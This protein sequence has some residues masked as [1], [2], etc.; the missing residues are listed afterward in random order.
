MRQDSIKRTLI[1]LVISLCVVGLTAGSG[2]ASLAEKQT[3]SEKLDQSS[4]AVAQES[5]TAISLE[6][7]EGAPGETVDVTLSATANDVSSYQ[8][9]ITFD[10]SIV[11]A[12]TAQSGDLGSPIV[13]INN[14]S[15]WV[16]LTATQV[17]GVDDPTLATITFELVGDA[18]QSS[19]LGLFEAETGLSD[20]QGN[21]ISVDEYNQGTVSIIDADP[22]YDGEISVDRTS[23]DAGEFVAVDVSAKA[24]DVVGFDTTIDFDPSVASV[25]TVNAGEF[26]EINSTIDNTT[27]NV[28]LSGDGAATDDP[29]LATVEFQLTGET[30]TQTDLL[31]D[32]ASLTHE[33]DEIEITSIT[34][35]SLKIIDSNQTTMAVES[36]T[37][38][39]GSTVEIDLSA[40]AEDVA[41]Y[42]A[43]LSYDSSNLTFVGVSG[44]PDFG[45]PVENTG[46]GWIF[47]TQSQLDGVDNPELATLTFE[48]TG[49]AGGESTL[50][51][52]A[53]ESS[54]SASDG[55]EIPIDTY[56]Q[57][58]VT[59][60]EESSSFTVEN[61]TVE[62]EY[63]DEQAT[64]IPDAE[65]AQAE[66][67]NV[68]ATV[69]NTGAST[70]ST[71]VSYELG[72]G[73]ASED[74][75]VSGLD[76]GV[77]TEVYVQ[78]T[79]GTALSGDYVHE[80]AAS[81]LTNSTLSVYSLGDAGHS[82]GPDSGDTTKMQQS[83]VGL[84]P[85]GTYNPAAGD[86]DQDGSVTSADVTLTQ[87]LIVG[88]YKPNTV[89]TQIVDS[90]IRNTTTS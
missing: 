20:S 7:K 70:G 55:Q 10:P 41:G 29:L 66:T 73:I 18:G 48:V 12:K 58:G 82:A 31:V 63:A 22:V 21:T 72:N 30:G 32:S 57:G 51:L 2:S 68:T 74:I 11:S 76:A 60:T 26:G 77:S 87:Q 16:S 56:Q 25:E 28:E 44:T 69:T 13:N 80:F 14:E 3:V 86:L 43:N 37:A 35:G 42:Q 85:S 49:E 89:V 1:I 24:P 36:V 33:Q 27:G 79:L 75:N 84:S 64:N 61:I 53:E 15:G 23:G 38:N 45:S 4:L 40:S 62:N 65:A 8:A 5:N 9:N 71:T 46:T 47:I 67:I 50:D 81:S 19:S 17:N 6:N 78:I 39:T 34:N 59:I 52:L 54:L 90:G 83:I 88:D